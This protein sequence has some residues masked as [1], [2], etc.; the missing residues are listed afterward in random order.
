V[1]AEKNWKLPAR[2]KK[3]GV[4]NIRSAIVVR[5]NLFRIGNCWD[6]LIFY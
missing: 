3:N 6:N 4:N 1:R 5:N 2:N